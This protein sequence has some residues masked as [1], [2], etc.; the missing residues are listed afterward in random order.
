MINRVRGAGSGLLIALL[1]V[2]SPADGQAKLFNLAPLF[3]NNMVVERESSVPVWGH[4]IPGSEVQVRASWGDSTEAIT[5]PD[6]SWMLKLRTPRAGGPYT[7]TVTHDD[8]SMTI[9]NVLVGEVWLCSGQ[10]NMEMPLT[11]WPPADTVLSSA[12]EITHATYPQLRL[13][14]I[15]RAFSAVPEATCNAS[16]VE[17]SP[18][19]VPGFSATAFFFGKRLHEVLGVPV[20]VIQAAWGGTAVESWISAR[21]LSRLPE[22]SATLQSLKECANGRRQIMEWLGKFRTIDMQ[23]RSGENRWREFSCG[24]SDCAVRSYDDSSWRVMRLP[25]VWERT[26]VG[27]LDG[28][29]WFRKSV[30]IPAPWVGKNLALELGPVDDID[31]TYV[32]GVKVGSHEAEGQWNVKRIYQVPGSVIDSTILQ[33]SVRVIDYQGGGGIYGDSTFMMLHPEQS[34]DTISIAGDW[35]YLPIAQLMENVVYVF[36]SRGNQYEQRPRFPLDLSANTPTTLY[37]GMIAPLVPFSIRG[38]IW[39]QGES[40]TERPQQYHLLFPLLI[41]N[42]RSDFGAEELPFYF[43]Q[44]APFDYGTVTQ[45]QYLREAQG[46][47]LSTEN[48]GM[49][50]TLD[51]GNPGNIHPANKKEVGQRLALWALAKTYGLSVVYSGPIYKSNKKRKAKIELTFDHAEKGLVVKKGA[52]GNSFQIAGPDRV[53]KSAVVTVRGKTLLVSSPEIPHPVAVRY[54]FS[55]TPEATLFNS[56]GL[57]AASFRTDDWE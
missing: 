33:I 43:V 23:G 49:V 32:N 19:S 46:A 51:I 5:Q 10:S 12:D 1:V 6:S 7:L 29:V 38:A 54:A 17:C 25:T 15:R 8:T 20:G 37:N 34:G 40:N 53:F 16:W 52:T 2:H 47:A 18:A 21:C 30:V 45:S 41:E 11:G 36:G 55:N 31:V 44:I 26:E 13:C 28:I 14:T 27:N 39:Y 24:D 57:P 56:A 4:G 22:F 48:T 3:A 35:K 50:V 42:W 9:S